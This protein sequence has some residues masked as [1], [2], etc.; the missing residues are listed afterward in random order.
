MQRMEGAAQSSD[1]VDMLTVIKQLKT[2]NTKADSLSKTNKLVLNIRNL[3]T[4]YQKLDDETKSRINTIMQVDYPELLSAL[5]KSGSQITNVIQICSMLDNEILNEMKR[6]LRS[7]HKP[8]EPVNTDVSLYKKMSAEKIS[9]SG[10]FKLVS[11]QSAEQQLELLE[12][13]NQIALALASKNLTEVSQ[14]YLT[15]ATYGSRE[16]IRQEDSL[17]VIIDAF[18]ILQKTKENKLRLNGVASDEFN[19]AYRLTLLREVSLFSFQCHRRTLTGLVKD[20]PG[21]PKLKQIQSLV[22]VSSLNKINEDELFKL[23]EKI[24][25]LLDNLLIAALQKLKIDRQESDDCLATRKSS[26]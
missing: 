18:G 22:S 5:Q 14:T 20:L 17:T 7:C 16:H 6:V 3:R 2:L 10:T 11:V 12:H 21:Y 13:N 9:E 24:S 15:H 26:I 4:A 1:I 23:A 19:N 8:V 25:L